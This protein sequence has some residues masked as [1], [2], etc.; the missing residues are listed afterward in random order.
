MRDCDLASSPGDFFLYGGEKGCSKEPPRATNAERKDR[1]LQMHP[2]P[3]MEREK[4][5]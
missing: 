3:K 1:T 2:G 5:K 4:N